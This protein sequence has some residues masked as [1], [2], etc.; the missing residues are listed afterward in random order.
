MKDAEKTQKGRRKDAE[1]A[2][3]KRS[4]SAVSANAT[5]LRFL[6]AQ[7][8]NGLPILLLFLAEDSRIHLIP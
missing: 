6:R 3:C 4:D 1:K 2:F 7:R 8:F 5:V